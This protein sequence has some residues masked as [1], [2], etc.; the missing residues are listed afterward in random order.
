MSSISD[1]LYFLPHGVGY[2]DQRINVTDTEISDTIQ[3]AG[4]N[5]D[6]EFSACAVDSDLQ[7][8]FDFYYL[9]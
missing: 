5:N 9:N 3:E 7:S 8:H 6:Q 4:L 1:K 2:Q